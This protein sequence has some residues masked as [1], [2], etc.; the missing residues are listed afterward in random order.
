PK[1]KCAGILLNK[2]RGHKVDVGETLFTI[3]AENEAKLEQAIGLARRLEPMAIEGMVLARVPS[4][5]RVTG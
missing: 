5:S 1:D 4:F 3:Y 2:K